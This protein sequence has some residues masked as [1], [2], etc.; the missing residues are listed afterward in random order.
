M[1]LA[2]PTYFQGK[3]NIYTCEACHEHVVTVD[4]D[5]GVTPFT[6]ACQCTSGCKGWMKSS[7]Y[8]V[9]DQSMKATFEWYRPSAT[10]VLEP[11]EATHVGKGGL[12]L[13]RIA[14]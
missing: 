14:R 3:K 11:W 8:R 2:A 5:A 4:R 6:I 9:F 13:R 7:L 10:E 1:T 12:L